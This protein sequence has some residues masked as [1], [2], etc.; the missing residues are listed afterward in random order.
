M[1]DDSSTSFNIEL[2]HET[3]GPTT[4]QSQERQRKQAADNKAKPTAESPAVDPPS[5]AASLSSPPPNH[6]PPPC[7]NRCIMHLQ[8]IKQLHLTTQTARQCRQTWPWP[9]K[10]SPSSS[11]ELDERE[12]AA[13]EAMRLLLEARQVVP[14][15]FAKPGDLYYW[16]EENT[17]ADDDVD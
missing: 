9:E 4:S 15:L 13:E 3:E 2:T 14:A 8:C 10:P 11:K 1:I 6:P 16:M 5:A 17:Y 12:R 7:R